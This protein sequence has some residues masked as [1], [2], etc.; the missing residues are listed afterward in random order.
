MH[1]VVTRPK[2]DSIHLIE[3]LIKSGH[4]VTHLPVIKIEKL[5]K[6]LDQ[7]EFGICL[8]REYLFPILQ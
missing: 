2:E 3:N 6:F 4:M 1:V 7:L 5:K 8:H